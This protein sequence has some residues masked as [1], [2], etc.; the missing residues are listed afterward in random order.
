VKQARTQSVIAPYRG[1][2]NQGGRLK[3]PSR[4]NKK[5]PKLFRLVKALIAE[6]HPD[7]KYTTIQVNKNLECKPHIDQ[8]NVGD[9]YAI[10]FGEY[11]G[12]ELVVEGE[13]FN[14]RNRWKRF[15]G[16]KAHWVEP[17]HGERYSLVFFT[18][19]F[20]PPDRRL[21]N[22]SVTKTFLY[23]RSNLD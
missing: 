22:L 14:I 21:R 12:G 15:D 9:S 6:Y 13:A 19:T 2:I 8:N 20:K 1:S 7:F 16:R 23:I 3:G 17:F 4:W 10:A 11:T 18:H 5:F